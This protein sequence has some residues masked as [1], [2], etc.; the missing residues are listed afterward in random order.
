VDRLHER[1]KLARRTHAPLVELSARSTVS[2]VERDAA[3]QR[4][5]FSFEAG[6]RAAQLFL[7]EREGL[8]APSPKSAIRASLQVGLLSEP[9]A[10]LALAMA[11]DRNL[12]VHTYN[13]ELA[14]RI[15]TDL[16]GCLVGGDRGAQREEPAAVG[17]ARRARG[18]GFATRLDHRGRRR[19]VWLADLEVEDLRPRALHFGRALQNF[20]REEGFDGTHALGNLHVV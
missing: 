4:F 7:M 3:I 2:D 16:D 5:E 12:T 20:H 14:K 8:D 19:E 13:E 1:L 18:E 6:W 15:F 17:V 11:D 10:R 9:D